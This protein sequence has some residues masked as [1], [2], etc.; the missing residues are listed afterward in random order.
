MFGNPSMGP[1]YLRNPDPLGVSLRQRA[2][3]QRARMNPTGLG[4][5]GPLRDS[6]W[7]AFMQALEE[8]GASG[9]SLAPHRAPT[10]GA[11][12]EYGEHQTPVSSWADSTHIAAL[13][14]IQPG[15]TKATKGLSMSKRS[16]GVVPSTAQSRLRVHSQRGGSYAGR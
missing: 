9:V 14:G 12:I 15:R 8:S 6:A 11:Q 3:D 4:S 2:H 5:M 10:A 7:D 1:D 16:A 13:D